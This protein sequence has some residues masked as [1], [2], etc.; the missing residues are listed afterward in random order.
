M[1]YSLINYYYLNLNINKKF[2][3][4][5]IYSHIDPH[6]KKN[7]Y[8]INSGLLTNSFNRKGQFKILGFSNRIK[9][10]SLIYTFLNK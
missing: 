7:I 2:K 5:N 4:K 1:T 10:V 8:S 3:N 9:N 6:L